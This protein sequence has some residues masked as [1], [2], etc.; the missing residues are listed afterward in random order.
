MTKGTCNLIHRSRDLS[1]TRFNGLQRN[2][3]KAH[4]VGK[5]QHEQRPTQQQAGGDTK[6]CTRP[7]IDRVIEPGE[8]Q[9]HADRDDHTGH[10]IAHTRQ[11]HGKRRSETVAQA[12]AIG[13]Q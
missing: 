12:P 11:T 2:S 7:R 6:T 10:R 13:H 5:D 4:H 8:R 3:K 9:H 1:E